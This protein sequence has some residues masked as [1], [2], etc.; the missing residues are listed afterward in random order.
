MRV[1]ELNRVMAVHAV[2]TIRRILWEL[3]LR[4]RSWTPCGTGQLVSLAMAYADSRG[5]RV[6]DE[7]PKLDVVDPGKEVW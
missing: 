7:E 1:T 5:S 3:P 2:E 4:S 6:D